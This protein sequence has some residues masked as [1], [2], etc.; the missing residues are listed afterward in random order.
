MNKNNMLRYV[1]EM[2]KF[3][4]FRSL[5]SVSGEPPSNAGRWSPPENYK[6]SVYD[7]INKTKTLAFY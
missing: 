3:D 7:Q 4:F 6:K 2:S 5:F 1:Y